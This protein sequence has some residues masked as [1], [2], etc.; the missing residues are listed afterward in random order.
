MPLKQ[1]SKNKSPKQYVIFLL[2]MCR[3]SHT[4][5]MSQ[6]GV[7]NLQLENVKALDFHNNTHDICLLNSLVLQQCCGKMQKGYKYMKIAYLNDLL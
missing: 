1:F 2:R 4:Y 5:S 6:L 7:G 3:E